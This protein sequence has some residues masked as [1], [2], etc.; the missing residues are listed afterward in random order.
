MHAI[1]Q[2]NLVDF[3][4]WPIKPRNVRKKGRSSEDKYGSYPMVK[5]ERIFE[6]PYAKEQGEKFSQSHDQSDC[7]GWTFSS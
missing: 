7:K 4:F 6:V 2:R 5:C 1:L 3:R